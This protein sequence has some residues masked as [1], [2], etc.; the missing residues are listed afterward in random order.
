MECIQGKPIAQ[1]IAIGRIHIAG[2]K[3]QPVKRIRIDNPSNEIVR[4]HNGR[5]EAINLLQSLY[6]KAIGEVGEMNAQVFEV[7]AM[8]L[9]DEDYNNSVENIIRSQNVN[10]EYAVA[11]TCDNFVQM[12]ENM[13]DEYFRAR[14]LDIR[15]ISERVIEALT[16]E[17]ANLN[18]KESGIFLAHELT[19]SE[20]MRMDKKHIL[21][22][23]TE[24]GSPNSHTAILARSMGIPAVSE[25]KIFEEWNGKECAV[26]GYTG[27]LYIEPDAGILKKIHEKQEEQNK[28]QELL[29]TLKGK[30]TK[31]LLYANIGSG[32]DVASVLTND[33][34]GIG[35]FRTEFLY[36]ERSDYPTE[37]E[38]FQVYKYVAENMAGRRVIIR[39]LDIGADKKAD[40]FEIPKEENP[41]MGYRAIR[42]CL[43]KKDI[44]KTQLR[45]IL[46]ASVFGNIAVMFPM[47]TSV[48]EVCE[49]KKILQE[50]ERE[51]KTEGI[52]CGKPEVGI[53]IETPAAALISETLA[54]EV[55]FFSIG[56]N[57]LTQYTLAVDRQNE[58]L[59]SYYDEKHPAIMNL[60]QMTIS[61]GH[62]AGIWVGV[63][64]EL[65]ADLQITKELVAMGVDELSV[66]P[67][68]IL[69]LRQLL[70]SNED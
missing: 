14:S 53:M 7:H 25:I 45:A 49:A 27:M 12:F 58:K 40:Y 31:V 1:G 44:F 18:M 51:L 37:Q 64:G 57:D 23:V 66:A 5:N 17:N 4:Y 52:E 34:D 61:N 19:P 15:D 50:A 32:S 28:R 8:M 29:E 33:A 13:E 70:L 21:A 59:D 10:A 2:A 43:E 68:M 36:L 46:R 24:N 56:T 60:I 26:D 16:G 11:L 9:D 67:T 54:L 47:I 35:L 22:F 48:S 6:E 69:P 3:R 30:K 41:A 63:C 39:T 55:D 62:K 38:Q 65:A 20:T 42:I